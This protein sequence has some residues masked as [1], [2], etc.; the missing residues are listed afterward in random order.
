MLDIKDDSA[1]YANNEEDV[2][3]IVSKILD[4]TNKK[5][6]IMGIEFVVQTDSVDIICEEAGML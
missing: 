5:I 2:N 6:D 4:I 3:Y 1:N